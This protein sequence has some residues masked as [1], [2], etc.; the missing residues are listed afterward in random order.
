MADVLDY[1]PQGYRFYQPVWRGW[2]I[3]SA[4]LATLLLYMHWSGRGWR[5]VFGFG[6]MGLL[7]LSACITI[8][9][10][11]LGCEW[12]CR[13]EGDVLSFRSAF[14]SREWRSI[15]LRDVVQIITVHGLQN[16]WCEVV[17]KGKG[18]T[19]V[20]A[21]VF[22]ARPRMNGKMELPEQFRLAANAVNPAIQFGGRDGQFCYECRAHLGLRFRIDRCVACGARQPY[23]GRYV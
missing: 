2:A 9:L 15:P 16:E 21:E 5:D 22:D 18:R 19:R 14:G 10:W 1:M 4:L 13:I 3:F 6:I 17:V 8:V 23:E 20:R 11:S 12:E 7:T